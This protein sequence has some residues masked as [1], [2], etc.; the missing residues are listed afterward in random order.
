MKEN[1][2][3]PTKSER[4]LIDHIAQS[5]EEIANLV[6]LAFQNVFIRGQSSGLREARSIL[7]DTE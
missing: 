3:Q 5:S 6:H 7:G 4:E 2:Y 1:T